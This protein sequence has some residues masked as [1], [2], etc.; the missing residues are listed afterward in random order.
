MSRSFD[1][2]APPSPE[3]H[4]QGEAGLAFDAAILT[5]THNPCRVGMLANRSARARGELLSK[6]IERSGPAI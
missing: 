5:P 3:R 2:P 4:I 6:A 1:Q